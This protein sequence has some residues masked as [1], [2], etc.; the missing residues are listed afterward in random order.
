[1]PQV[2]K[3]FSWMPRIFNYVVCCFLL[4]H[5]VFHQLATQGVEILSKL[6]VGRITQTKKNRHSDMKHT[7]QS[8]INGC[9]TVFKIYNMRTCFLN[10]C[11]HDMVFVCFSTVK[12][13]HKSPLSHIWWRHVYSLV[14]KTHRISSAHLPIFNSAEAKPLV[15]DLRV[16]RVTPALHYFFTERPPTTHTF[17][18]SSSGASG[19]MG[20][21]HN[22][23]NK[24]Q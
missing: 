18:K 2:I 19:G 7:F 9:S 23:Y 15:P 20:K 21:G 1:M 8:K 3:L 24:T 6:V 13:W 5:C 12:K 22:S 14:R 4:L 16:E 11:Y 10:I 17:T